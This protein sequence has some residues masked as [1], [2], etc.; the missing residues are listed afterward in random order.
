MTTVAPIMPRVAA[1]S[2]AHALFQPNPGLCR[3]GAAPPRRD[4]LPARPE[5]RPKSRRLPARLL[6]SRAA[7][8]RLLR[9]TGVL[10]ILAGL[11]TVAYGAFAIWSSSA[12]TRRAQE[13]L[14]GDFQAN[15]TSA[16]TTVANLD[17]DNPLIATVT[18]TAGEDVAGPEIRTTTTLPGLVAEDPPADGEALGRIL[19]PAA[20]VNWIVVEGVSTEDLA[21]GP[22]HMPGTALPGQPGNAV[23]SGH[24]TT[25][26]A[27]F[28]RLDALQPGDEIVVQT[29]I[30]MHTYEVVEVRTVA[31]TDMWVTQQV[32]GSWLTLT[33]CNPLY[34]ST[35]RLIVFAR[36]IDGPNAAAISATLTGD[37]TPPQPPSG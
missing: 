15:L 26:G 14:A 18:T 13:Q 25:H 5:R 30:G 37:E 1:G 24:R 2:A 29:L 10:L 27:P 6:R 21:K 36:L 31:P 17:D 7:R 28:F 32:A 19:I 9:W 33:T 34:H 8:V 16:T 12:S 20:G 4:L 11:G 22:G 23:I 35:Q 3:P